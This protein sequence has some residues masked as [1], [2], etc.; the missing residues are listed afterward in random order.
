M[1]Q[2]SHPFPGLRPF[3]SEESHLFFGRERHIAEVKRKIERYRFVSIVGNSGSGKSSLVRAGLLPE[4]RSSGDWLIASL[5]PGKDPI[6]QLASTLVALEDMVKEPTKN[7]LERKQDLENKLRK[8]RLGIVQAARPFVQDNRKLLLVIDQF[9][10]IFRFSSIYSNQE[11][12]ATA[13]QFVDLLLGAAS[14]KEVA[15]YVM[16]TLRSDY[17]GDCEQFTGLPEAIN[18]GQFLI[19][20]MNREE[21]QSSLTGPIAAVNGKISPRLVQELLDELGNNPDQLPILQHAL[22]RAWEVWLE[23]GHPEQPIDLVHYQRT[24]GLKKALSNHAE[25]AFSELQTDYERNLAASIFKTI[26]VKG[27]DNR[28]IR[29][30]TA[31]KTIALIADCKA[32]DLIRVASVFRREDRGFIM[33]AG[34]APL[35]EESILDISHESLMRIW[36]RLSDWVQEEADSSQLYRRITESAEWY[37]QEKAGL[38]RDPD[39]Q[40]AVDWRNT[41]NPNEAWASQYNNSFKTSIRFIEASENEK[42][43]ALAEKVRLKKITNAV[44]VGFLIALSVLSIWAVTERN[45][46]AT[47]AQQAISE[48]LEAEKQKKRAEEQKILAEGNFI[49]AKQEENKALLQQQEAEKQRQLALENAEQARLA[50]LI[51]EQESGNA[52]KA[53]KTAD[54]QRMLAE[55]QSEISDSLRGISELAEKNATRLQMLALAQNLAIKSRL[56]ERNTYGFEVKAL[57]ALQAYEFNKRYSG[58]DMDPEIFGALFSAYRLVQDKNEY[59]YRHHNAEVKSI[60]YNPNSGDLVS[61]GNDGRVII[62][63]ADNPSRILRSRQTQLILT[64]VVYSDN[65]SQIAISCDDHSIQIYHPDDLNTP[66]KELKGMHPDEVMAIEWNGPNLIT[67][68]LDGKIRLIDIATSQITRTLVSPSRP[69]CIDLNFANGLLAVGCEDGKIYTTTLSGNTE[70]TLFKDMNAG[71]ILCLSINKAATYIA[72]GSG[73]GNCMMFAVNNAN[74][75]YAFSGHKSGITHVRF[76]PNSPYFATS[77]R[78]GTVRL[79]DTRNTEIPPIIF[80]E[81]TG[82]V[83]DVVFSPDGKY[84]ASCGIDKTVRTYPI[85]VN[86]MVQRLQDEIKRNFT[87]QEWDDFVNENI[88]YEKTIATNP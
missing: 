83:L 13:T 50:R 79:F 19:P 74:S 10:E 81:H 41:K 31:I 2:N 66:S 33:P 57:L 21:L 78:D 55:R 47:N 59:I 61:A 22:M 9:E 62:S 1:L 3:N 51:A 54:L 56:A 87:Q 73:E 36:E 44:L 43:F 35:D 88:N 18:D 58:R 72:A 26:T 52:V 12:S 11:E 28:G 29:R 67:A 65:G 39:L 71:R 68:C 75:S 23:D 77:S 6:E 86:L 53:K 20:R 85:Q 30:P 42:R 40:I 60:C 14:Q 82:W 46:S 49:K 4:L 48:K 34:P 5:R 37:E 70:L 27:A 15:I 8:S 25:E 84:L 16:I 76:S 45:N 80:G 69:L 24:G 64:N 63:G 7:S 17:L 38:W 32:T